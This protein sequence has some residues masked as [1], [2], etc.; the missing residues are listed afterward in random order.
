M[1]VL[2]HYVVMP[3]A[4]SSALAFTVGGTDMLLNTESS[5]SQRANPTVPRGGNH[6]G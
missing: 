4:V 3:V 6:M 1:F 5:I 2:S